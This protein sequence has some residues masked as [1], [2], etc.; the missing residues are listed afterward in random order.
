MNRKSFIQVIGLAFA[1]TSHFC[2]IVSA[3]TFCIA[4]YNLQNYLD[5]PT[6]TRRYAKSADARAKIRESILKIRP[7]VIALEEVGT[8]SALL[9]LRDSLKATGLDLPYWEHVSGW[10][11]NIHVAVLSR[12]PFSARHPHTNDNY[13]LDGRRFFVSR[14]FAEVDV[15]VNPNYSFTL[16]SAHLKSKRT[17]PEADQA[18]MRLEEAKLLRERVEVRLNANPEANVVVLGDFNDTKDSKST[19]AVIGRG[20]FKLVDTRPAEHNGDNA[21]P[22]N[23]DWDPGNITWTHFYGVE[24]SYSRID[25]I[26]LSPGMAKEWVTNQ[27]YVLTMPNWSVGS[28]HRPIVATFEATNK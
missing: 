17:I 6:Q 19:K 16:I 7:D 13:L 8:V 20:K 9:E 22:A 14:G 18:E 26:M 12:F 28:D 2:E 11:T 3:E 1:V 21:P 24:D 4:T 25:Y 27:T 10:D 15:S 23:P 5:K